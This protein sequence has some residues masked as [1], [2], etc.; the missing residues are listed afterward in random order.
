M[1]LIFSTV[2]L[3]FIY[4][5]I[6]YVIAQVK[7]NNS[8][9]DVGWGLGFVLIS[10]FT[11]VMSLINKDNVTSS[12][13]F[14]N[15]LF[16][17]LIWI[18]GSRLAYYIFKRNA[19]K[20]EDYRYAEMRKSWGK[21]VYIR[22]YFQVFMLQ[23]LLMLIIASN[24]I[25]NNVSN[26]EALTLFDILGLLIWI[27]GFIFESFGDS[28]LKRFINNPSNKGKIMK[29]GL[30]KYTRHPNYFGEA[31]MWW[32]IFIMTLSNNNGIIGIVSPMLI[33]FLLLYVSGVPLL[34]KK[35]KDNKEFQKYAKVTNK[36]FPWLPKKGEIK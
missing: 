7:K 32:G 26:T 23:G 25:L 21:Q 27:I 3:I 34:E 18:W 12:Y 11:L 29:Y 8:I 20:K 19:H 9:V 2:L 22:G 10:I 30:W 4:M 36:F 17:S 24:I 15:I 6:L 35:Y 28:Q 14:R 33:T 13:L 16:N 5:N 31:T 1:E